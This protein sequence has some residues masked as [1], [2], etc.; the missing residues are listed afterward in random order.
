[1]RVLL[2]I[3]GLGLLL[4]LLSTSPVAGQ[5]ITW[6]GPRLS[7][8]EAAEVLRRAPGLANAANWPAP[9]PEG[10]QILILGGSPQDGPFGA[11]PRYAPS[12]AL[13]CCSLYVN[14]WA[15]SGHGAF[16]PRISR[17]I[18]APGISNQRT[19]PRR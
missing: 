17:P 19:P 18:L 5:G 1:M 11:F 9:L 8:A 4:F 13:N 10:P 15:V 7:P 3:L 6:S 16:F 2:L 14:G 12:R